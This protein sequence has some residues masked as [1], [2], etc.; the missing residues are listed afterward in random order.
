MS[1]KLLEI[2][3]ARVLTRRIGRAALVAAAMC[4]ATAPSPSYAR[5]LL[6]YFDFDKVEN[7]ALV[8]EDVNK[9]TGTARSRPDRKMN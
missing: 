5:S 2:G 9:G 4:V 6:Y 7:G 3:R 1:F 8:Y